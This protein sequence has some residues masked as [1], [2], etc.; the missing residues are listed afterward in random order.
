M[1]Q[2]SAVFFRILERYILERNIALHI[3]QIYRIRRILY[4]WH[5]IQHLDKTLIA[6]ISVLKLLCKIDQCLDRICK[7]IDI[8]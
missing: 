4:I 5:N 2:H 3:F 7:Y 1:L 8:Q 6:R